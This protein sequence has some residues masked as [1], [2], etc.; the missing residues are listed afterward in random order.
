MSSSTSENSTSFKVQN[1]AFQELAR[2]LVFVRNHNRQFKEGD[3][4]ASLLMFS[5]ASLAVLALERFLRILPGVEATDTDTLPNLLEKATSESRKVIEL[6][7]SDRADAIK[8]INSV[9]KTIQHANYEQAARECGLTVAEYFK[10]QFTPE[11]EA[12]YRITDSI[13]RQIDPET[14]TRHKGRNNAVR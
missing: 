9:R 13:V 14:G 3:S 1:R 12:I 6:P 5:E 7:A 11:I 10:T 2:E 4:Q 8:R